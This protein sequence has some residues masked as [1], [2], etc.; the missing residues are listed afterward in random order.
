MK[1]YEMRKYKILNYAFAIA[2]SLL[3]VECTSDNKELNKELTRIAA[4][5]NL[6]APTVLDAHMRFDSVGVSSDNTLGYYYTIPNIDN[7]RELIA[8]KKDDILKD[9]DGALSTDRTLQFYIQNKVT[10]QFIYRDTMQHVVDVIT[11]ETDKYK[12]NK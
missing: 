10:M 3:L 6:S 2:L 12:S 5:L 8:N 1:D 11:I 4:E 7:P 9:M